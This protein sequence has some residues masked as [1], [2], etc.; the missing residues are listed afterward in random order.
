[1]YL[2]DLT[3]VSNDAS[4]ATFDSASQAALPKAYRRA[5]EMLDAL[6]DFGFVSF[7]K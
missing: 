2:R 6:R 5:V 4:L 3:V 1:V 7:F